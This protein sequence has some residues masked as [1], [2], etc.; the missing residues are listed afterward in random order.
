[1]IRYILLGVIVLYIV[2]F[3]LKSVFPKPYHLLNSGLIWLGEKMALVVTPVILFLFYFVILGVFAL[4]AKVFS[5]DLL[6]KK[7]RSK[8]TYWKKKEDFDTSPER[9]KRSF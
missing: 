8:T 9:L 4:G 5:P 3:L 1:M 6:Q 7:E 2:L